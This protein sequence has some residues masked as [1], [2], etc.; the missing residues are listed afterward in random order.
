MHEYNRKEITKKFINNSLRTKR[1]IVHNSNKSCR[2]ITRLIHL[3]ISRQLKRHHYCFLEQYS[4]NC[5]GG[6]KDYGF[7]FKNTFCI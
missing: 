6:W 5:I 3:E 7:D 4:Y 2:S 1:P